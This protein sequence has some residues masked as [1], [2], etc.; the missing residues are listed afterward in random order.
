MPKTAKS[1]PKYKGK[2][3]DVVH[4]DSNT[5]GH[6]VRKV[7][8]PGARK[9]DSALKVQQLR[10][11]QLNGMAGMI[12]EVI[13]AGY[14]NLFRTD[15]YHRIV[16]LIKREPGTSR[17]FVLLRLIG[18]E[19][20]V[21][22]KLD[23][24][25][26]MTFTVKKTKQAVVVHLTINEP[27]CGKNVDGNCYKNDLILFTWGG[28]DKPATVT[29]K[30]TEWIYPGDTNDEVYTATF[31]FPCTAGT[32]HWLLALRQKL[33]VDGNENAGKVDTFRAE[34]AQFIGSGSFKKEEQ[35]LLDKRRAEIKKEGPFR[36][37]EKVNIPLVVS[38]TVETTKRKI[39][40][41]EGGWRSLSF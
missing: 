33:G 40:P 28:N 29:R 3:G 17:S 38:E 13:K 2:V 31:K 16:K 4:V 30:D 14:P 41:G 12:K 15:L 22:Y 37:R 25:S 18:M 19:I 26:R 8:T 6:H 23:G 34:G 21:D 36:T 35:A 5:Y 27:F 1:N 7:P 24:A 11:K 20:N 9:N 32:V 10:N 39:S